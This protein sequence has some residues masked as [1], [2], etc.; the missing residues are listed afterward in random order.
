MEVMDDRYGEKSIVMVSQLPVNE[1]HGVIGDNAVADAIL[2]R[3]IHNS[4]RL[5]LGGES[6]RKVVAEKQIKEENGGNSRDVTGF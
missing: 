4:H 2:D 6:M 5:E 3:I 1:W